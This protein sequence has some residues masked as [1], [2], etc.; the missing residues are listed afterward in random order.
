MS[1]QVA[2]ESSREYYDLKSEKLRLENE[3]LKEE[4]LKLKKENALATRLSVKKR[5]AIER[6][7]MESNG[8]DG[9]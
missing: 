9:L 8:T 5:K 7:A 6:E 4:L 3:E 2:A 1:S